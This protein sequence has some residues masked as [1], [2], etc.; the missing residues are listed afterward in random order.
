LP[1]SG[2]YLSKNKAA[3]LL[4]SRFEKYPAAWISNLLNAFSAFD[5]PNNAGDRQ[6]QIGD[7]HHGLSDQWQVRNITS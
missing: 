4:T 2:S 3:M 6:Q 5:L 1:L 7:L